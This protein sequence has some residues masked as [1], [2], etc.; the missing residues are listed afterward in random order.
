MLMIKYIVA[1]QNS[2]FFN[3]LFE[4]NLVEM[5]KKNISMADLFHSEVFRQ[6]FDYDEWPST[7]PDTTKEIKPYNNSFLKLRFEYPSVFR[8][9]WLNDEAK[10]VAQEKDPYAHEDL[11]KEYKI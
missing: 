5:M 4:Y 10:R 2:H 1:H 9:E 8:R 6:E 11:T 3:H 7:N